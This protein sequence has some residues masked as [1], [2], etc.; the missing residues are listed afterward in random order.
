MPNWAA[1]HKAQLPALA[2]AAIGELATARLLVP[3]VGETEQWQA[4]PGVHL[5]RVRMA[6]AARD[7]AGPE[8]GRAFGAETGEGDM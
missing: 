2:R 7:A 6:H 1:G 5:W 3:V 4:T 8:P